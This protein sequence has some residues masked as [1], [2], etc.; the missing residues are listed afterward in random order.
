MPLCASNGCSEHYRLKVIQDGIPSHLSTYEGEMGIAVFGDSVPRFLFGLAD[1]GER[2]GR[3]FLRNKLCSGPGG[4]TE[5]LPVGRFFSFF[6]LPFVELWS[7]VGLV[8][9]LGW[10]AT[11]LTN[12]RLS[13]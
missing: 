7:L 4:M 13:L 3:A 6:S 9:Q 5:Q 11:T 1:G 12:G 2:F 10:L 8:C